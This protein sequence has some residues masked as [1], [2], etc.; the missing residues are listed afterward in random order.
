MLV[1]LGLVSSLS[2]TSSK[3]FHVVATVRLSF[4]V[5]ADHIL[6]VSIRPWL[7]TWIVFTFCLLWITWGV[8]ILEFLFPVSLCI[9]P[10][11]EL[12]NHMAV[13]FLIF[14]GIAVLFYIVT[15]APFYCMFCFVICFFQLIL[16]SFPCQSIIWYLVWTCLY[17]DFFICPTDF[18]FPFSPRTLLNNV[19]T[20]LFHLVV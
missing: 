9:Y 15:T 14:W 6:F 5:C 10:G 13:L 19:F 17:L 12:L 1:F 16:L 7:N 4:L 2:I 11:V 3:V 18:F 8:Q 20:V